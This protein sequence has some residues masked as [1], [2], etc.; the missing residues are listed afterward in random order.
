[1]PIKYLK[2]QS[3]PV[4]LSLL[5]VLHSPFSVFQLNANSQTHVVSPVLKSPS[6]LIA[7]SPSPKVAPSPF[8]EIP[9]KNENQ[10]TRIFPFQYLLPVAKFLRIFSDLLYHSYQPLKIDILDRRNLLNN[11]SV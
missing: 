1:M 3:L 9:S 8:R 4:T 2:S 10:P 6:R 7:F 5:S 11:N